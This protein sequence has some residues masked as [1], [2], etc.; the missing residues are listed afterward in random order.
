MVLQSNTES[1]D[2]YLEASDLVSRHSC[3][4]CLPGLDLTNADQRVWRSPDK[5]WFCLQL[6]VGRQKRNENVEIDVFTYLR[7]GAK[8]FFLKF[9]IHFLSLLRAISK[10]NC[11]L[12]TL[13]V[14]VTEGR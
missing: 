13:G 7:I 14:Q 6:V 2:G 8:F 11:S 9:F 4:I 12:M 10:L 1:L 5:I 3:K